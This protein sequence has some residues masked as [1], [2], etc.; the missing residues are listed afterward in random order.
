VLIRFSS[1]YVT[2]YYGSLWLISWFI[3]LGNKNANVRVLKVIKGYIKY[4][5]KLIFPSIKHILNIL[6]C[7]VNYLVHQHTN[8]ENQ[9]TK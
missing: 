9:F 6:C 1:Q 5:S 2:S 8:K 4:I 3:V 7:G